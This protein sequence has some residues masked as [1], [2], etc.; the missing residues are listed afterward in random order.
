MKRKKIR[1]VLSVTTVTKDFAIF[2]AI[3]IIRFLTIGLTGL[4]TPVSHAVKSRALSRETPDRLGAMRGGATPCEWT[5]RVR[6]SIVTIPVQIWR[7]EAGENRSFE[8][9]ILTV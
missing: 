1:G 2:S 7:A 3:A 8:T 9:G 4:K 5:T 6:S